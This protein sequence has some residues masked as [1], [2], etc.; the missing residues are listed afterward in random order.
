MSA[1]YP[2]DMVRGRLTVQTDKSHYRGIFHCLKTISMEEGPR[3]FYKGW[4]PSVIGVLPYVELSVTTKIACG[5]AAGTVGQTVAY[6]L[7]VIRRRMQMGGWKD[8]A[9]VVAGDGTTR[10]PLEYAAMVDAF[11]KTVR[12]E[13][14]RV[15]Y[16]GLSPNSVKVVPSIA[17]AFVTYEVVKDVLGAEMRISD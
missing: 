17:I 16:K 3:A 9:S 13:G 6:P 15:L 4:L 10:A 7:D 1:T 14:I 2:M 11:R 5:A 12:H 8:A